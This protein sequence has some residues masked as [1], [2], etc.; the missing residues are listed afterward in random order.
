MS[1]DR[2]SRGRRSAGAADLLVRGDQ[3]IRS[4][5]DFIQSLLGGQTYIN[6][7]SAVNPGGEIRGQVLRVP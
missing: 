6:I 1:A 5:E 3:G 4:W 7:H 2:V